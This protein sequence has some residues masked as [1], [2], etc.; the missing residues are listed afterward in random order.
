MPSVPHRREKRR[1]AGALGLGVEFVGQSSC[2][3]SLS[4]SFQSDSSAGIAVE[5]LGE[6]EVED[7]PAELLHQ[8]GLLLDQDQLALVDDA[9]PVGHL[10]GFLDVVGG[11]D[12]GRAVL[13]QAA[14]HVP[15]VAAKLD[16]DAGGR[17]VEEQDVGIVARAPWR[18]SPG[19][20]CRPTVP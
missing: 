4:S 17:L 12:D 8:L 15:H 13:A 18:S 14:D 9:D 19:A 2:P 5:R 16:V 11:E 3:S 20:S 6:L 7:L 1:H 10:L